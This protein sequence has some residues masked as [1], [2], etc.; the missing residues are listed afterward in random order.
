[1]LVS[2]FPRPSHS[3]LLPPLCR[4]PCLTGALDEGGPDFYDPAAWT[5][6]AEFIVSVHKELPDE[7]RTEA[8]R[9]Q[10]VASQL[11]S[12]AQGLLTGMCCPP[13]GEIIQGEA[14]GEAKDADDKAQTGR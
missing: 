12:Q 14:Q 2:A 8:L 6:A 4:A 13:G 7:L 9:S 3:T 10:Q 5:Q 1:M 11:W